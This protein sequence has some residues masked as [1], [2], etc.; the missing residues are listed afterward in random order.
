M[1]SCLFVHAGLVFSVAH[2]RGPARVQLPSVSWAHAPGD[3]GDHSDSFWTPG[4]CHERPILALTLVSGN[5]EDI[6]AQAA[7]TAASVT[8]GLH[9]RLQIHLDVVNADAT[10]VA[11]G[12]GALTE[13][14][15]GLLEAH[16]E[17]QLAHLTEDSISLI[18]LPLANGSTELVID[19]WVAEDATLV[20]AGEA[21]AV[22]GRARS[23]IDSWIG[24][25]AA[26]RAYCRHVALEALVS[27]HTLV[28]AD[29][30][31]TKELARA[32]AAAQNLLA[33]A[34][35]A[36]AVASRQLLEHPDLQPALDFPVTH[37][38]AVL[39]PLGLPLGVTL[40]RQSKA[41]AGRV[42]RGARS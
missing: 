32:H 13:V 36:A 2:L 8:E 6:H 19:H 11:N 10:F 22:L 30:G 4:C 34:P 14:V 39:L 24:D 9:E 12:A 28:G 23:Q 35:L 31:A 29:G 33:S 38:A 21:A 26:Q 27:V 17:R 25:S 7:A 37:A 18:L 15:P 40:L 1:I 42:R 3:Q 20:L 41:W 16:W 5:G